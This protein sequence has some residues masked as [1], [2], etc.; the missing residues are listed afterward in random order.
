MV[1]AR[2]RQDDRECAC[3]SQA[4]CSIDVEDHNTSSTSTFNRFY[5]AEDGLHF[6]FEFDMYLVDES[7]I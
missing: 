7:M 2:S 3:R 1:M 6:W 4:Y 5:K